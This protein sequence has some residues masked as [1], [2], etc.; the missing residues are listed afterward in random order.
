MKTTNVVVGALALA[1]LGCGGGGAPEPET[2][3]QAP[4][5]F[6]MADAIDAALARVPAGLPFEVEF[7]EDGGRE[8]LE[9]ELFVG[10]EMR[11]IFFEP[12]TG[13]FVR[14]GEEVPEADEAPRL[15]AL[16]AQLEAG[17]ITLRA[18]LATAAQHYDPASIREVELEIRDGRLVIEIEVR[19]AGGDAEYVHDA[20]T[21]ARLSP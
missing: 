6:G 11:E 9:V 5:S 14:E 15:P 16:R 7:D 2:A 17:A 8:L 21:F 13:A 20:E 10:E 18:A 4:Q 1:W 12:G 3:A 19:E